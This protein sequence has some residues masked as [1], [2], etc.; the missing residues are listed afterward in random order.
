MNFTNKFENLT[1]DKKEKDGACM[2]YA[3]SKMKKK[4][5]MKMAL[6]FMKFY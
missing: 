2:N 3:K 6:E 5:E 1:I 4:V